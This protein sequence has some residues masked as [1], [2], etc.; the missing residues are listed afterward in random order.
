MIEVVLGKKVGFFVE[1]KGKDIMFIH[2]WNANKNQWRRWVD[3]LVEKGYRVWAI[4]LPGFGESDKPESFWGIWEYVEIV[5]EFIKLKK[6]E[7]LVLVGHS[8]G[9]RIALLVGSRSRVV[10]KLLVFGVAVE[11]VFLVF[12]RIYLLGIR[13]VPDMF[14]SF[15]AEKIFKITWSTK[16]DWII[17]WKL[18]KNLEKAM[19]VD[20][21]NDIKKIQIP[22][23]AAG[24]RFDY[25]T[26]VWN[27]WGLRR[28]TS[29][30]VVNI[31]PKSSHWPDIQEEGE[32]KKWL[33]GSLN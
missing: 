20:I 13:F 28:V 33:Y 21:K 12:T 7:S 3:G 30:V 18:S 11:K 22:I 24:G 4:D 29:R 6:I 1:G 17:S 26:P 14:R 5:E 19:A 8:F 2:G 31:F 23:F 10:N 25:L 27:L 32:F 9:S 15:V 16:A